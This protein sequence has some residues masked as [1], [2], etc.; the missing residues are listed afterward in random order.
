M[1]RE[2]QAKESLTYK[3]IT[4][5]FIQDKNHHSAPRGEVEYHE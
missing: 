1:I 4:F 3:T 2:F 5:Q